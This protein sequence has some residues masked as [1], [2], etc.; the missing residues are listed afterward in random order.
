MTIIYCLIANIITILAIIG[1]CY[2]FYTKNEVK[3]T[4]VI[5]KVKQ[6]I[7][8]VESASTDLVELKDKLNNIL[9]KF[10]F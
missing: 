1:I 10:P 9:N 5:N 3:I 2:Y 7:S 4:E 8:T 6:I